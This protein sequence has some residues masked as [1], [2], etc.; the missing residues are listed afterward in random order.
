MGGIPEKYPKRHEKKREFGERVLEISAPARYNIKLSYCDRSRDAFGVF[1][2]RTNIETGK[3]RDVMRENA[4]ENREGMERDLQKLLLAYL[5]KW[6]IIL[7]T[8]V[9]AAVCAL[10]I[11]NHLI[12]PLYRA[13]VTVYVN[14]TAA[15]QQV[16]Y[17]SNTNLAT[18]QR[19]VSTYINMIESDSVL[20]K[21]AEASGENV[22]PEQISKMMSAE[23][24]GGTE[25]F[26]VHITHADPELAA[27]LANAMAE[28]A[29][30]EIER[31]VEGSS[32][33]IIDYAKVPVKPASPNVQRNVV[34]GGLVG[35]VAAVLY[36]TVRFLL[37]VRIK[38]EEDLNN[39]FNIPVLAQ[40]PAFVPAG[41]KRGGYGG[42]SKHEY[43]AEQK[44]R[45]G[46]A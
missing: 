37:D 24:V 36:V 39:L 26:E 35:A 33:K 10:L 21:V 34:L 15:G 8:A 5:N 17:V 32:T 29:P 6:W 31:F 14:N 44:E 45:G 19:L 38:D 30:G 20:T 11:T 18:S 25:I 12:T 23:Q 2:I 1:H 13:S 40:I 43:T 16:D 28:V 9:I 27:K 22:T 42:Y 41:S 3:A 4:Y 7:V 46:N